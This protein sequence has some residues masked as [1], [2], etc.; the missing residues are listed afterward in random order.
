MVKEKYQFSIVETSFN[1]VASRVE[2]IRKKNITKTG[3]RVYRDDLIGIFGQLGQTDREPWREA[4]EN[5]ANKLEY[6]FEPVKD[7]S[8]TRCTVSDLDD[9][10]LLGELEDVLAIARDKHPDFKIGNKVNLTD[11]TVTLSNDQ[12]TWLSHRDKVMSV[13][14]LLKH[15]DSTS[16]F[17][18]GLMYQ[19]RKWDRDFFLSQLEEMIRSY[20]TLLPLP[21]GEVCIVVEASLL[22]S[23]LASELHGEKVGFRSSLL[24]KDFGQQAFS[25]DF[26]FYLDFDDNE[27][28]NVPFFDAEGTVIPERRV[29]LIKD[30]VVLKAYT[31]RRTAARFGMPLTGSAACAY[32]GAP[33]LGAAN[34]NIGRSPKT[35]KELL[36]GRPGIVIIMASGGDFT[37]EGKFASPVQLALLTDG[38]KFLGRLPEFHISGDLYDIFGKNFIGYS[39]DRFLAGE[40]ALVVKMDIE[41]SQATA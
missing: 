30:G 6:P 28:Y 16:I 31:D 26:T 14:L 22:A 41:R 40:H 8:E 10:R 19:A 23:K 25:K 20:N 11:T 35:V 33:A 7:L 17:D 5:L 29:D 38:E 27:Q 4:E 9:A 24:L 37:E 21:D 12:G 15:K 18:T 1:I 32:D 34:F 39:A 3:Y 36:N 2:S 13:G